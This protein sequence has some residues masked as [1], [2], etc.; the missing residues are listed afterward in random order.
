[1]THIIKFKQPNP[2]RKKAPYTT[3]YTELDNVSKYK[4][5]IGVAMICA[6]LESS[7]VFAELTPYFESYFSSLT[8]FEGSYQGLSIIVCVA[9]VLLGYYVI[10][11][12][13][14]AKFNHR[15]MFTYFLVILFPGIAF[16]SSYFFQ[17]NSFTLNFVTVI[18]AAVAVSTYPYIKIRQLV[19]HKDR[20]LA[21]GFVYGFGQASNFLLTGIM[22]K[23]MNPQNKPF[24]MGSNT[25]Y[26][27]SEMIGYGIPTK[28]LY[29]D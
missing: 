1:M 10:K 24:F 14:S 4:I 17:G 11:G 16:F 3:P 8:E 26:K 28:Q 7:N 12:I 22:M 9:K 5:V 19:R 15:N 25:P 23:I 29:K 18:L 21:L 20:N 13:D 27:E 2:E 6:S